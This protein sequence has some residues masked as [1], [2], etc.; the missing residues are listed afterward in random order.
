[1]VSVVDV[2]VFFSS[3]FFVS[4]GKT[5]LPLVP[6]SSKSRWLS[7]SLPDDSPWLS[8][9]VFVSV[10]VDSPPPDL[11][12]SVNHRA[13]DRFCQTRVRHRAPDGWEPHAPSNSPQDSAGLQDYQSVLSNCY[14]WLWLLGFNG[15][16]PLVLDKAR[17]L[18]SDDNSRIPSCD[19]ERSKDSAGAVP[20][21]LGGNDADETDI[22][23]DEVN[24]HTFSMRRSVFDVCND[25]DEDE[26]EDIAGTDG[27]NVAREIAEEEDRSLLTTISPFVSSEL[28]SQQHTFLTT[29]RV[30]G[31]YSLSF[32][33][34]HLESLCQLSKDVALW[35][36]EL[37][38][39]QRDGTGFRSSVMKKE[40]EV[41]PLAVNMHYQL[42]GLRE[43]VRP[44]AA[45]G[46][47]ALEPSL[48]GGKVIELFHDLLLCQ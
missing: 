14:D 33:S 10:A 29:P 22:V 48:N 42:L 7:V 36:S 17:E 16:D 31:E 35:I 34:K 37:S 45:V 47:A 43:H 9:E 1:L 27:V 40:F 28:S 38:E 18:S 39:R 25:E 2:S 21:A 23:R 8:V 44:R 30:D 46:A 32:I 41:Q 5:C 12:I 4:V 20:A 13:P 15:H 19:Q 26:V 6:D 3:V 24:E 11:I